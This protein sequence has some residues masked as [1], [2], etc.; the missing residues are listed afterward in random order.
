MAE[1]ASEDIK[2]VSEMLNFAIAQAVLE[3]PRDPT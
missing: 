1:E 2:G 3:S